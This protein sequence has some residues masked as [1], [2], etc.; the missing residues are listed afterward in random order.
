[1]Y[2]G[3]SRC[4]VSINLRSNQLSYRDGWAASEWTRTTD[5]KFRKHVSI[6]VAANPVVLGFA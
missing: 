1:M 4:C 2:R 5:L 6:A 3:M